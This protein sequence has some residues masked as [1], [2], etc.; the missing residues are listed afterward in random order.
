MSELQVTLGPR[1]A[2]SRG[3]L[4]SAFERWL[5]LWG[6]GL[7]TSTL[8]R[9]RTPPQVLR[10]RFERWASVSREALE[11]KYPALRFEDYPLGTLPMEALRARCGPRCPC[12]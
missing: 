1:A 6:Y 11:R 7:F 2:L 10:E 3:A 8:F 9:A 12:S 4:A 5:S